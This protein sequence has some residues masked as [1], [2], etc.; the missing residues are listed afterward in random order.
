VPVVVSAG[1]IAL[2]VALNLALVRSMGYRGLALGTSIAALANA[3]ALLYL[4]RRELGG[5][6]ATHLASVTLRMLG[7]GVLMALVAWAAEGALARVVTGQ[8]ALLQ[9]IRVATAIV[10]GLVT[11]AATARLLKVEEFS[12]VTS[13]ILGRLTAVVRF[14]G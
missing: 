10:A 6:H 13:A 8:G 2:N 3:A 9:A 12:E 7:A 1:A 11:L 14:S 4:L 5:L